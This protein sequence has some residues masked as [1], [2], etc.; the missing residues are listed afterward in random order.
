MEALFSHCAKLRDMLNK[1][2]HYLQAP[3]WLTRRLEVAL[4]ISPR[5]AD[6]TDLRNEQLP[7]R[8]RRYRR[9]IESFMPL[10]L[11]SN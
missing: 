2:H 11:D 3:H 6:G 5:N 1:A 8:W 7:D 4:K 10:P 9:A